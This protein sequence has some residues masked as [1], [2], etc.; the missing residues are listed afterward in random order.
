MEDIF[1]QLT[2]GS[3]RGEESGRGGVIEGRSPRGAGQRWEGSEMGG[4]RERRG[5]RGQESER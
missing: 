4:I 3:Q 5:Q 2:Q 1:C